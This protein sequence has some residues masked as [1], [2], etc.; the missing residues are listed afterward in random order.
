M[1]LE[2][3]V[4]SGKDSDFPRW[5]DLPFCKPVTSQTRGRIMG[6]NGGTTIFLSE[7][8]FKNLY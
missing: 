1:R 2:Q 3:I 8:Y 7:N 6:R 4:C 5:T